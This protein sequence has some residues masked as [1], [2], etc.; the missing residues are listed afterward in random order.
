MFIIDD[1]KLVLCSIIYIQAG[2]NELSP[3]CFPIDLMQHIH[4]CSIITFYCI[5]I[6]AYLQRSSRNVSSQH[7]LDFTNIERYSM[8]LHTF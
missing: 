6:I 4:V 2:L 5:K 3:T 8:E 7:V 1:A